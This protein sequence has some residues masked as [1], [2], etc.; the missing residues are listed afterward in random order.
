MVKS[1]PLIIQSEQL[2]G[3]NL[4][5]KMVK[6]Q[7]GILNLTDEIK[8]ELSDFWIGQYQVTQELWQAVG[9][10]NVS[11]FKGY[12]RPIDSINWY[13]CVEFCHRINKT[14]R[15]SPVYSINRYKKDR[16]NLS[17]NYLAGDEEFREIKKMLGFDNQKWIVKSNHKSE[18]FRLPTGLEWI[19]AAKGG[20]YSQDYKYAGSDELDRSGWYRS[21]SYSIDLVKTM[22]G[23]KPVG[24]K[25]P[26]EL[27]LFDMLGNVIEWC[28][29]WKANSSYSE[30]KFHKDYKGPRSGQARVRCGGSWTDGQGRCS[31]FLDEWMP[32]LGGDHCGF[33]LVR[34]C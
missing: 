26:N 11:K 21:N 15:L 30:I 24:M 34:S 4:Q 6:V 2:R 7:G 33:R 17:D 8:V 18:G 9:G 12:N 1:T 28:W 25:L 5:F 3:T 22:A 16:N 13:D 14:M 23:S 20:I 31:I 19:Y 32:H 10:R 27:G 29:D